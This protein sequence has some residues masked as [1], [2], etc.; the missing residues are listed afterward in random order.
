[1]KNNGYFRIWWSWFHPLLI[2]LINKLIRL[3]KCWRA[4]IFNVHSQS[5]KGE[6][7]LRGWF[8]QKVCAVFICMTLYLSK[9]WSQNLARIWVYLGTYMWYTGTVP[10]IRSLYNMLCKSSKR[11]Q[12]W[13]CAKPNANQCIAYITGGISNLSVWW[14]EDLNLTGRGSGK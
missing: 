11:Q 13:R 8:F 2:K 4:N 5:V 6:T 9:A 12:I 7:R 1:M 10:T 14:A 3:W